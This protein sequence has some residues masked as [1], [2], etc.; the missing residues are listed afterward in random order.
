M[1]KH[2]PNVPQ[3]PSR[4]H[5]HDEVHSTPHTIYQHLENENLLSYNLTW[6][7]TFLDVIIATLGLQFKDIINIAMPCMMLESSNQVTNAQ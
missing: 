3:I 1:I 2:N 4:L 5:L 7:A 6:E